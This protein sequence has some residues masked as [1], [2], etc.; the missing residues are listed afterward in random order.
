MIT[1]L[2]TEDGIGVI[3][4][5]APMIDP[6]S[7]DRIELVVY[8]DAF[9]RADWHSGAVIFGDLERLHP[10]E[11]TLTTRLWQRF[12]AS[13]AQ[14]RLLNHPTRTMQRFALLRKLKALGIHDFDIW[15]ADENRG[16]MRF[17]VF[18]HGERDHNGPIGGLLHNRAALDKALDKLSDTGRPLNGILVIEFCETR[19][20]DGLY[21]MHGTFRVGDRLVHRILL[22]STEWCVKS[23]GNVKLGPEHSPAAII[24][25]EEAFMRADRFSPSV[26]EVFRLASVDYGR[27]DYAFKDDGIRVW[28][29]NTNPMLGRPENNQP[30]MEIFDRYVGRSHELMREALLALDP[31]RDD[32]PFWIEPVVKPQA[33]AAPAVAGGNW[34]RLFGGRRP[35]G[36]GVRP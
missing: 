32:M 4:G 14:V 12:A 31:E 29:I 23:R 18:L 17:P 33:P 16:D 36:A 9:R 2:G 35:R 34:R 6:L 10:V 24:D 20:A 11:Y 8:R 25:E 27:M 3:R 28:E 22:H 21:R 7:R 15:R 19:S 13:G 1:F 5:N 26:S 30:G